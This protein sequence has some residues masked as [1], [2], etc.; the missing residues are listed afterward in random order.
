MKE[1]CHILVWPQDTQEQKSWDQLDKKAWFMDGIYS[2]IKE[3]GEKNS[4]H[5][6]PGGKVVVDVFCTHY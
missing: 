1:Q 2:W 3:I 5:Q 6:Y 4:G